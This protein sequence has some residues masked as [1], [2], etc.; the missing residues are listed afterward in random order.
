[1]GIIIHKYAFNKLYTIDA[2]GIGISLVQIRRDF[3][4]TMFNL[5]DKRVVLETSF[6]SDRSLG[7]AGVFPQF[8]KVRTTFFPQLF[9]A[10]VA[11]CLCRQVST[12]NWITLRMLY[13]SI[14]LICTFL[15]P[16]R[17]DMP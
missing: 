8:F 13:F 15:P 2:D 14:G 7:Q 1:M 4:G 10:V 12:S 11:F 17:A 9:S 16:L 5:A 3:P 6:F